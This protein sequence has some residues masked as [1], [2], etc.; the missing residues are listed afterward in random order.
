M[1]A[2]YDW[3]FRPFITRKGHEK[4]SI[5]INFKAENR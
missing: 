3:E 4:V 2:N 5:I 1:N